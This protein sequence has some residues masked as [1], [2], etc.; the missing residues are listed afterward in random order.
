MD[1]GDREPPV[2]VRLT[3]LQEA[4]ILELVRI[5][6]DAAAEAMALGVC[7]D[8]IV[9]RGEA[10][11]RGLVRDHDVYVLEADHQVAGYLAWQD[12]APGVAMLSALVVAPPFRRFGLATRL[13][14]EAGEMA[15]THGIRVAVAV[16]YARA[17]D[18]MCFLAARGFTPIEVRGRPP[19]PLEEWLDAHPRELFGE[20][21]RL[22]CAQT[23]GLG[24]ILGLPRPAHE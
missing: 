8:T 21:R 10:E 4:Q 23:D 24:T 7:D 14:R 13:L 5:E 22:W 12:Q 3:G 11:I 18:T 2:R 16:C 9:M 17:A 6:A 15:A 1:T 20:G 19:A